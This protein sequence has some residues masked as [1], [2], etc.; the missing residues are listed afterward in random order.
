MEVGSEEE[1]MSHLINPTKLS[2]TEEDI[3]VLVSYLM[4]DPL[5][6]NTLIKK[7]LKLGNEIKRAYN[8][9]VL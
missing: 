2:F 9:E 8:S 4:I 3:K 6:N 5:A 1:T 7:L